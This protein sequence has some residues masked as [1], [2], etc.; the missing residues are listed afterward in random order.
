MIERS[1]EL[2]KALDNIITA[3]RDLRKF[4]DP[5]LKLQ[6]YKDNDW[7]EKYITEIRTSVFNI[8]NTQYASS[9]SMTIESD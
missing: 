6:Y 8:Y 1:C 2:R 7:E 5:Q 9:P 4:L 3:N